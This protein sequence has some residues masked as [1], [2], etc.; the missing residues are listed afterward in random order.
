MG[1]SDDEIQE[2]N[3]FEGLAQGFTDGKTWLLQ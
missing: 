1:M 2:Q 3:Q